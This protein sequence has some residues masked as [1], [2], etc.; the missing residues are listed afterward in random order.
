MNLLHTVFF[1]LFRALIAVRNFF[2]GT[3]HDA[4]DSLR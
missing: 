1:H 2:V 4:E 3:W